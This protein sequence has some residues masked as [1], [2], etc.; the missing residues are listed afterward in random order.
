MPT[1]ACADEMAVTTVFEDRPQ[2]AVIQVASGAGNGARISVPCTFQGMQ[3]KRLV[4]DAGQMLAV[5][6][7]VSIE[8]NDA[9]FLGEVMTCRQ[10]ADGAWRLDVKIEQILTGLESLI[11]LR[12]RLLEDGVTSPSSL[13][14]ARAA[15]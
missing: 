3:N 10:K 14:P 2:P 9:L 12:S 7:A 1:P 13:V 11:A 8:Y 5:S 6:T 15:K 4:V